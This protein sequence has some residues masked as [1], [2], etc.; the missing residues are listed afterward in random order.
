[1]KPL[2]S[3]LTAEQLQTF[4]QDGVL[5]VENVLTKEELAN[6]VSG[7]QETLAT[8]QVDTENLSGTG[9]NLGH[10]SSTNGSGG[11]LDLF[12]DDWK[13]KVATNAKLFAITT[14]LWEAAFCHHNEPKNQDLLGEEQHFK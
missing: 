8:H 9:H 12:Y 13:I 4:L 3:L 1:M 11:V 2:Q 7:L 6:A 14:E 5:V 10:L